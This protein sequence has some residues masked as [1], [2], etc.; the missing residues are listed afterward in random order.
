MVHAAAAA[1]HSACGRRR[2]L[3]LTTHPA[4]P[5]VRRTTT[6]ARCGASASWSS[7]RRG[8]PTTP[9]AGA[10]RQEGVVER[11]LRGCAQHHRPRDTQC[12]KRP[13]HL[14][15]LNRSLL[16]GREIQACY[17]QQGRK[18]PEDFKNAGAPPRA[19]ACTCTSTPAS[20]RPSRPAPVLTP[21]SPPPLTHVLVHMQTTGGS[22]AAVA[23][24]AAAAVTAGAA[25]TRGRAPRAT[26]RARATAA[27]AAPRLTATATA[28]AAPRR[29]AAA[30]PAPLRRAA[31]A[32]MGA[33]TGATTATA[34]TTAGAGARTTTATPAPPVAATT[35]T[36][37]ATGA[38]MTRRR[39]TA[40]GT[41]AAATTTGRRALRRSATGAVAWW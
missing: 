7:R 24:A 11:A 16:D 35:R 27:A 30:A 13:T 6:P 3:P 31:A 9:C 39:R 21:A 12:P 36:A 23:A 29:T 32:T 15:R 22:R 10:S 2:R 20:R 33:T 17:A 18:R 14:R 1:C 40:A 38:G 26:A 5:R 19:G 41:G 34:T 25:A 4:A 8:T 37:G 28:A